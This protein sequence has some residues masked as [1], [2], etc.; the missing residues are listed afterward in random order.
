MHEAFWAAYFIHI[1]QTSLWE[2]T[3]GLHAHFTTDLKRFPLNNTLMTKLNFTVTKHIITPSLISSGFCNPFDF[4]MKYT[5]TIYE[6]AVSVAHNHNKRWT[7]WMPPKVKPQHFYFIDWFVVDLYL[8]CFSA[9]QTKICSWRGKGKCHYGLNH[10][11]MTYVWL[12]LMQSNTIA[13]Q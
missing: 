5:G 12:K 3:V 6:L 10:Q 7:T 13:L 4:M 8:L 9:S 1:K 11:F 2:S